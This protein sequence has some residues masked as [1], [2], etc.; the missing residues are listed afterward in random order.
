MACTSTLNRLGSI[1]MRLG[2]FDIEPVSF[3]RDFV[4]GEH[5]DFC[6][7]NCECSCGRFGWNWMQ[8]LNQIVHSKASHNSWSLP[9]C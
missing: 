7:G 1:G 8:I 5:S 2:Q 6:M 4:G 3:E 9:T